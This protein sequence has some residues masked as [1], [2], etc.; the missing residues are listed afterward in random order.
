[1]LTIQSK[2]KASTNSSQEEGFK[3]QFRYKPK[4]LEIDNK[5][6]DLIFTRQN[7]Q[8]EHN[9]PSRIRIP[10]FQHKIRVLLLPKNLPKLGAIGIKGKRESIQEVIVGSEGDEVVDALD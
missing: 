7:Q 1:M 5:P 2:F 3:L 8:H 6:K 4:I 10:R 9:L